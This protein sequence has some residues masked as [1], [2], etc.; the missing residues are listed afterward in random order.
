MNAAISATE[1]QAYATGFAQALEQDTGLPAWLTSVRRTAFDDFLEQGWP[2]TKQE[3]WRFTD[4][5]P[6]TRLPLLPS[7]AGK[8]HF[9]PAMPGAC[10]SS[11][12]GITRVQPRNGRGPTRCS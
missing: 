1:R 4:V 5:T 2:T 12:D 6:I 9:S 8:P 10:S 3:D 11:T 7:P